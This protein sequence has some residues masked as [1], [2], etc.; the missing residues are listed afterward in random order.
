MNKITA[1]YRELERMVSETRE[2]IFKR[3][4]EEGGAGQN[5]QYA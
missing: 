3:F 5:V 4:V 1:P 2:E